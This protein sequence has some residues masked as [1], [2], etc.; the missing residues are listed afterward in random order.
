MTWLAGRLIRG[1]G[2]AEAV[3]WV[4]VVLGAALAT[5]LL[6]SAT[7]VTAVQGGFD[8]AVGG[9]QGL[10][11]R[12]ELLDQAGLRPG[13]VTA[14]ILMVVPVLVFL[15]MCARISAAQR[16]RRLAA[17][18]LAG[19]DPGQVRLLAAVDTAGPAA[20]GAFAGLVAFAVGKALLESSY[21]R[22]D[23]VL[24]A[25]RALPTDVPLP[26]VRTL[27]VLLLV[28]ALSAASAVLALRQVQ[29]TPLGVSR[30][31]RPAPRAAG[32]PVL[33][34]GALLVASA[35]LLGNVLLPPLALG[36]ALLMIGL[37]A[38]SS[39]LTARTGALAALRARR[40]ALLL[41]GRRLQADPHAQ[42]RALAGVLLAVLVAS[43]A[44]V[45]R[46][47]TLRAVG[48]AD[49]GFY[50]SAYDLVDLALLVALVV[51]AAGLVV[52]A[53]EAVLERRR[54]LASLSAAGVPLAVLRRAVL[55]QS[56]LPAVP[57]VL[58]ATTV[59]A[60][61]AQLLGAA[62]DGAVVL[63]AGRLLAVVGLALLAV[64]A[65]AAVTLPLV[66]RA[67]QPSELRVA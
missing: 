64:L 54:T 13:V 12:T 32:F 45:L 2:R 60:G 24:G 40:P 18:R 55:L 61:A 7:L 4:L 41:A 31:I 36:T 1:S 52:A 38:S 6:L 21:Q 44:A 20:L 46:A 11:Y 28:P 39:W 9:Q 10:A 56:L 63:P 37:V 62:Q 19:A 16:D 23:A 22:T 58:L 25:A 57:A 35:P 59:G 53:C 47:T 48:E 66:H 17:V 15:G 34:V 49:G 65:A 43:A 3:R 5:G 26:P 30:R 67:V 51:A 42:G 33:M 27:L 14:L 8:A 29:T 50:R